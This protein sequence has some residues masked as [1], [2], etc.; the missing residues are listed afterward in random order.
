MAIE[1]ST[2][3]SEDIQSSM[4]GAI[5]ALGTPRTS[6]SDLTAKIMSSIM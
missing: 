2:G 3:S 4:M 5:E 1:P 6:V